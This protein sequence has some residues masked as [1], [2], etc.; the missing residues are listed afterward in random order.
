MFSLLVTC[1]GETSWNQ[2]GRAKAKYTLLHDTV[3]RCVVYQRGDMF[4]HAS[5]SYLKWD[6]S[7]FSFSPKQTLHQ[8]LSSSSLRKLSRRSGKGHGEESHSAGDVLVSQV[9]TA[10]NRGSV[11]LS[12]YRTRL[13][14]LPLKGEN[15]GMA[16]H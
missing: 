14:T 10:D 13:R 8:D 4:T 11:S 6:P 15:T 9:N 3:M 5:T 7:Y 1:S 2:D 12:D 16:V